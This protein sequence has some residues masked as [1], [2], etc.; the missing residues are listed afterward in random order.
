[1]RCIDHTCR[2]QRIFAVRHEHNLVIEKLGIFD[3]RIPGKA[4]DH[5]QIDLLLLQCMLDLLGIL[6]RKCDLDI[7]KLAVECRKDGWQNVLRGR[8]ARAQP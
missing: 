4:L 2:S 8:S 7:M 3:G 5:A 6:G 1:M